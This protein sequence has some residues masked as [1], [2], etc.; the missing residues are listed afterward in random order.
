MKT[1]VAQEAFK[2]VLAWLKQNKLPTSKIAMQK[3]LFFL[4][5]KGVSL[6]LDFEPYSYGPFSKQ[7]ME[8]ASDFQRGGEIHITRTEYV[9]VP[10]LSDNLTPEDRHEIDA[11]LRQFTGFLDKDFSFDNLELFGTVLYCIQALQENGFTADRQSVQKEFRDWKG[12]K[13][14]DEA[15]NRSYDVLAEGFVFRGEAIGEKGE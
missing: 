4:Q 9:A 12:R 11:H 5:E 14:S 10:E 15:I 8:I 2:Y 3:I 1:I 7:V 13:F 6:G